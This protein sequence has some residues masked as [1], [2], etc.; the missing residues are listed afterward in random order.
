LGWGESANSAQFQVKLPT[1]AEL[2]NNL[3][4][5][6]NKQTLC[7][8]YEN[9]LSFKRNNHCDREKFPRHKIV[10]CPRSSVFKNMFKGNKEKMNNESETFVLCYIKLNK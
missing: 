2:G 5:Y 8:E 10:L 1:G 7:K 6:C 4:N 3:G 9:Y